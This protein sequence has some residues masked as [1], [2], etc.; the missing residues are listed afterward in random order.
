MSN[1]VFRV[2]HIVIRNRGVAV[3]VP[4]KTKNWNQVIELDGKRVI[5]IINSALKHKLVFDGNTKE[6]VANVINVG[7]KH[8]PEYLVDF[9]PVE[10]CPFMVSSLYLREIP[11]GTHVKLVPDFPTEL[12]PIPVVAKQDPLKTVT[13]KEGIP[14][15]LKQRGSAFFFEKSGDRPLSRSDTKDGGQ[16]FYDGLL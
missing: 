12:E 16:Q 8:I 14:L 4:I 11:V 7:T 15:S 5:F 13:D 10:E 1:E 6:L 3:A 2:T 9:E